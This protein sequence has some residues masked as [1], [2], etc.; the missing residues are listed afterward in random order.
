MRH[1]CDRDKCPPAN[2]NGQKAKCTSCGK[3][4]YLKCFGIERSDN[5][6]NMET[7]RIKLKDG[8]WLYALMPCTAFICCDDSSSGDMKPM[9]KVPTTNTRGTSKSRQTKSDNSENPK[10]LAEL[11][12]IKQMISLLNGSNENDT[13]ILSD[14]QNVTNE[15][16]TTTNE[17]NE[18]VKKCAEPTNMNTT[19]EMELDKPSSAQSFAS[20]VREQRNV[21]TI[22]RKLEVLE[23]NN[24]RAIENLPPPME[25]TGDIN[26][27]PPTLRINPLNRKTTFEKAVWVSGLDPSVTIEEMNEFI[28][29]NTEVKENDKFECHKLVKKDCD[30][31]KLSYISFKIAVN[32]EHF[33]HLLNPQI[34]PKYVSVREFLQLNKPKLGDFSNT[35]ASSPN[36]QNHAKLRKIG[37]AKNGEQQMDSTENPDL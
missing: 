31:S 7:I 33:Q 20:I 29:K 13:K 15:I 28:M 9:L 17:T 23:K 1:K 32:A 25:G 4:C 34:W 37:S 19:N 11:A 24:K 18:I 8:G 12:E 5:I 30:T 21:V 6:E 35:T 36:A 14:V 16:K 22:K 3:L 26:I 10:I 2:V 27:G